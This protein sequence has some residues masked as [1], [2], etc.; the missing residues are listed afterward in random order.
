MR[1]AEADI[2]PIGKDS[3]KRFKESIKKEAGD[4]KTEQV[5]TK[6]KEVTSAEQLNEKMVANFDRYI[7]RI[8]NKEKALIGERLMTI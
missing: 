1:S 2:V 5:I 4:L 6:L 3:K 7:K 8:Q